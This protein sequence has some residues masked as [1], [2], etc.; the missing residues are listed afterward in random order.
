VAEEAPVE[1]DL[2]APEDQ[3]AARCGE[4][5]GIHTQTDP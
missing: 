1:G 3:S 4:R 5:V 2:D